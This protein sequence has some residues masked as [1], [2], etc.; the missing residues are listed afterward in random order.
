MF[1]KLELKYWFCKNAVFLS[2]VQ[3]SD[4]VLWKAYDE[5]WAVDSNATLLI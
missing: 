4:G 3:G 1:S 2:E 5:L